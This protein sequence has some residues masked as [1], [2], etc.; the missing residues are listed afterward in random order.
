MYRCIDKIRNKRGIIQ[1]YH[2]V[3]ISGQ[4][5]ELVLTGK[6]LNHLIKI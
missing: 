3:D 5:K 1:L 2:L 4:K 6:E